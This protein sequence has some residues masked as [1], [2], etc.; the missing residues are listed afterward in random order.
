[1]A[2]GLAAGWAGVRR[3]AAVDAL[4]LRQVRRLAE[5]LA[6]LR[7]LVRPFPSVRAQV[8]EQV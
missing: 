2:E 3:L 8:L 6:A 4:V 1:M 7:A 5:G